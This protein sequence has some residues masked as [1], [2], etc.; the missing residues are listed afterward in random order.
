[1]YVIPLKRA[2]TKNYIGEQ[3]KLEFQKFGKSYYQLKDTTGVF[4]L[5]NSV[6]T[7]GSYGIGKIEGESWRIINQKKENKQQQKFKN[8]KGLTLLD[9]NI[10]YCQKNKLIRINP[11]SRDFS[12]Y[13]ID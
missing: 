8:L 6:F 3:K 13:S 12:D 1:M 9:K 4:A 5:N 2:T 11:G 10:Y 7:I